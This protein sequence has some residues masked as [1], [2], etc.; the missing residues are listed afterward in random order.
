MR[1]AIFTLGTRGDVQPYVALANQAVKKGHRAVICTG[2]T[3]EKFITDHDIEFAPAES[4]L[5]AMLQTKEG[6]D[7][8]NNGVKHIFTTVKYMKEVV[9][10]AYRKTLDQFWEAAQ[11]AD[12]I[13]YHPKAF[14]S[15]DMALALGIPCI[16]MPPVPIT[17]PIP[18]FPNLAVS[19]TKNFGGMINKLTYRMMA[20]G[21]SA[22]IK[23]LNDF[24]EKT[25]HLPKRKSGLYSYQV[26][27]KDIPIIYPV[28][29]ALFPDVKSWDGRVYL[30]GFFFLDSGI[31]ELDPKVK[32]F[33]DQGSRP[34]VVSFSSMPLKNPPAFRNKLIRALK[35]TN[36]RAVVLTGI[37]GMEFG[38]DETILAVEQAPHALLFPLAKGIVHHGGVG[39][40][41]AAL[42]SG[43]P[44]LII[45]FSVDQPFWA[46]RL[47]GMG[48][49]IKPLHEKS[50]TTR[51]L[52]R[53]F[54]D[55]EKSDYINAAEEIKHSIEAENGT[56]N[57]IEYI[58][59]I[60][61]S[62]TKSML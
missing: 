17:F 37:S 58:E 36:N 7:V 26:N 45:P 43:K 28:S 2:K 25:L 20:K 50:L 10:P 34:V 6:Q 16:S 11:G 22:S 40:M 32:E 38:D 4:D 24:R 31:Q 33:V 47:H 49:A 21:E 15:A 52:I 8:F 42:K 13:L 12:V 61:Y 48:Y 62:W 46:N 59:R 55:M 44:Q 19:S 30:P 27:G 39:T 51:D 35:Q 14:G 53:S 5:M 57:A 18:E 29:K 60:V 23:E 1:I 54:M 3:F 41:A 9:N 56:A